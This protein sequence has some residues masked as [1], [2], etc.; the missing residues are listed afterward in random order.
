[1]KSEYDYGDGDIPEIDL[2]K[3]NNVTVDIPKEFGDK[4]SSQSEESEPKR[5]NSNK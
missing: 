5:K 3:P 1:M 2:P 4:V